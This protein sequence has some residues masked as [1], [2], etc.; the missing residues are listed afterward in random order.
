MTCSPGEACCFDKIGA[1]DTCHTGTT[2]NFGCAS[3]HLTLECN[4]DQDCAS[5]ACCVVYT[6][7]ST[8][9]GTECRATCTAADAYPACNPKT[10]TT[11]FCVSLLD[12]FF[13]GGTATAPY[14]EYGQCN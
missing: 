4:V 11:C 9:K 14:D 7:T 2:G 1:S 3:N 13:L 5:G 10:N 6:T 12:S 8:L